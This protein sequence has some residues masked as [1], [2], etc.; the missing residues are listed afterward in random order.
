MAIR[1]HTVSRF[2]LSGFVAPESEEVSGLEPFLWLGS[3]VSGEVKRRAPRKI[4]CVRG[5]YDGPGCLGDK[6][7]SIEDHL[8]KIES[9]ASRAIKEF[10]KTEPNQGVNPDPAIWRFLAWQAARTPGW[11]EQEQEWASDWDPDET[12]QLVESPPEGFDTV[13]ATIR[14]LCLEEPHTGERREID[15]KDLAAYRK[16]GWRWVFGL[17]DQLELMHLQAWYFQVRHFPRLSWIRLNTPDNEWFV[18]SDRA[19]TWLADGFADTPPA[20]LRHSK[21][22]VVAPLTRR[23][24]LVGRNE[25]TKLGVTPREINRFIASTASSWL[26]GPTRSV[27]EQAIQDRRAVLRA[28]VFEDYRFLT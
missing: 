20:A 14:T 10:D 19:V 28:S 26:A 3:L 8:Q 2:Y 4:S 5:A 16:R 7:K 23:T 13:K 1:A 24:A 12:V 6:D 9:A 21:A 22:Q 17:Q 27:V 15:R 18:T 11:M 25:T